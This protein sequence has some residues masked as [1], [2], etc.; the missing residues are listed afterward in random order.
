MHPNVLGDWQEYDE[1]FTGVRV[2]VHRFKKGDEPKGGRDNDAKGLTY[3]SFQVTV[4]NGAEEYFDLRLSHRQV[5]IRVGEEGHS[6]FID[7]YNSAW[8]EDFRLY[9][10]RKATALIFAA[11]PVNRLKTVDI[12]I[13][14]RIDDEPS[15]PYVWV[16]SDGI[17]ESTGQGKGKKGRGKSIADEASQFL[18][19]GGADA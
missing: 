18:Q 10:L 15:D 17:P 7:I 12:Q 3:F 1:D 13:A 4:E 14:M 6:A 9:P 19:Q 11:A 16:G 8:I 5:Q 2:R